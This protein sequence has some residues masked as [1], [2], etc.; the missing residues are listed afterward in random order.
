MDSV[1]FFMQSEPE[2]LL[3]VQVG[4]C[5]LGVFGLILECYPNPEVFPEFGRI[6]KLPTKSGVILR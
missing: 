4:V 2:A 1:R 5:L 6:P 3:A